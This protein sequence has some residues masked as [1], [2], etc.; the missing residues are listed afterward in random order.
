[1]IFAYGYSI[2]K[3]RGLVKINQ[4]KW[5]GF[6]LVYVATLFSFKI[7]NEVTPLDATKQK[8]NF[9]CKMDHLHFT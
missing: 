1:M 3:L 8:Q 7:L 4:V 5:R 2:Y 9:D 6:I